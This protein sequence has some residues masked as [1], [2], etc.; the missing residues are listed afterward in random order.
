M[1]AENGPAPSTSRTYPP[2]SVGLPDESPPP[3]P[4]TAPGERGARAERRG[5]RRAD[6]EPPDESPP[7][8]SEHGARTERR[9]ER[10]VDAEPPDESPPPNPE[11]GARADRR[12]ERRADESPPPN[13]A[14]APGDRGARLARLGDRIAEL[15]ARIQAATYELLV[16]IREF[17]EQEGWDGC[18]S[19]AEWLSWRA[20]S[21]RGPPASTC[22]W[23][24]PSE[25]CRS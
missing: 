3:N 4:E 21:R 10:R 18:L 24:G 8:N 25:S 7:P 15:S 13:R 16:L 20:G 1:S 9:G 14:T 19:C 2:A 5:D 17:D 22:A 6:V 11:R 23:R 12:G